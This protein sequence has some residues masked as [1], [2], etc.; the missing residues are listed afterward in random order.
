MFALKEDQKFVI[1]TD[2]RLMQ[3]KRIAEYSK[4]EHFTIHL[5]CINRLSVFKTFVMSIFEWLLNCKS[6]FHSLKRE[7]C[8]FSFLNESNKIFGQTNTSCL[9]MAG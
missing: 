4:G 3:V 7:N 9:V 5:T 8:I 1:K 2:Y 6:I